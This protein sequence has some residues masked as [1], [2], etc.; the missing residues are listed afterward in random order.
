[1]CDLL[2]ADVFDTDISDVIICYS[3]WQPAYEELRRIGCNFSQGMIDGDELD[4]RYHHLCVIDDLMDT[5][6]KRIEQF[7]IRTAHHHNTSVIYIVQNLFS[8]N[9]GHR[10]ISLNTQ[11]MVLFASPRDKTQICVLERQMFPGKKNYLIESYEDAC[12]RPYSPLFIDLKP[13]TPSH[14]R[15]RGNILSK[16]CQEVYLPRDFKLNSGEP[17]FSLPLQPSER[18]D[19]P[20]N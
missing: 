19:V 15:V 14:L 16:E 1:M 17:K 11:Y 6:D 8:G 20:E 3:E 2:K 5:H 10:T 9:R 18:K 12:S 13:D 4:P 7:F